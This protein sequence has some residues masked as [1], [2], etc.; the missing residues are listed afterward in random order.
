M[1]QVA[2]GQT[3]DLR[4]FEPSHPDRFAGILPLIVIEVALQNQ[5]HLCMMP[6]KN[7]IDFQETLPVRAGDHKLRG[8]PMR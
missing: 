3:Q 1:P 4:T 7:T 5:Q 6:S 2:P 8:R